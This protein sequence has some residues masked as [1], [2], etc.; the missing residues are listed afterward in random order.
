MMQEADINKEEVVRFPQF[1]KI[2][3]GDYIEHTAI[4]KKEQ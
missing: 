1:L 4:I 2:M 3:E